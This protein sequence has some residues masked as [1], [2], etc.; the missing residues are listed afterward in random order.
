VKLVSSVAVD[1]TT[2]K[3]SA[4][5]DYDFDG[6]T[7]FEVPPLPEIPE[8]YGIGL[9]VGASGSGKSSIL[10]YNFGNPEKFQWKSDLAIVSHFSG[11]EEAR[12][13]LAAVGLNSVPSMLRPYHCL[14]NGEQF[15]A[16]VAIRLQ[17]GAVVDEFTSVVDRNVARSVSVAI[18]RYVDKSG[19]RNLVIA[20]CHK[21]IVEWLQ[22]DWVYDLDNGSFTTG[23]SLQRPRMEL[24]LYETDRTAWETFRRHHYL[25]ETLLSS[26]KCYVLMMNDSPVAF[27]AVITFPS[28]TV[29]NAYREHRTVVLPDFQGLGLGVRMSDVC[30]WLQTS[31]GRRYYSKTSHYRFG[32][33]RD[34]AESW[35]AT[36]HNRVKRN[37]KDAGRKWVG[38]NDRVCYSHEFV[39]DK[40]G[41][42][43][44]DCQ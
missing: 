43:E 8:E 12:D 24:H 18:R 7:E 26:S 9:I 2:E 3:F 16:D 36:K 13:K 44:E 14:S 30:A 22:P 31:A 1:E 20:S 11:P 34:S 42:F 40:P 33:Y 4:W 19:L 32:E 21:D 39:G 23:R 10:R 41:C 38:A 17:D 5:F 27:T 6:T 15:R 37:A 25:S 29:K 28:G 35:K